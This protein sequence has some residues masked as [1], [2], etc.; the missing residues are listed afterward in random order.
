ML[1]VVHV[2][3]Q[4]GA[5]LVGPTAPAPRPWARPRSASSRATSTAQV[6][7]ASCRRSGTLTY[8]VVEALTEAGIGQSTCV[9]IGGDPINGLE[10]HRHPDPFPGRSRYA[11]SR[12]DRRDRRRRRGARSGLD[13]GQHAR[14]ADGVVH[15]R[16]NGPA[17][18][19]NGP[20]RRD[21]LRRPRH[22]HEQGQRARG[23]RRPRGTKRPARFRSCSSPRASSRAKRARLD[24]R[25]MAGARILKHES[26]PTL[27]SRRPRRVPP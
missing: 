12:A 24:P 13:R 19:T 9:G 20:R 21:H 14:R 25:R 17:R 16:S 5:R 7:S 2:V 23:C 15:R 11:R 27:S 3:D 22:G 4:A 10:L 26:E 6:T 8:E 1:R 18:P